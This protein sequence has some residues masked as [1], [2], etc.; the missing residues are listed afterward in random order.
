MSAKSPKHALL[1]YPGRRVRVF[2]GAAM[3]GAC[4]FCFLLLGCAMAAAAEER[5]A[6]EKD[7]GVS[8]VKVY[9]LSL[10]RDG[11]VDGISTGS[12]FVI[13]S[14]GYVVTNH[15]VVTG[16]STFFVLPDG[17]RTG[18]VDG[19]RDAN[20]I[21][22]WKSADVDL[23]LLRV[24]SEKLATL[25]LKPILLSAAPLSKGAAVKAIGFPGI[26]DS[27]G[28]T[29]TADEIA[30]STDT[31]G[32][33]G[34]LIDDGHMTRGGQSVH[35][36]QHDVNIKPGSSG[37]PLIDECGRVVGINTF[38]IQDLVRD[39][40]GNAIGTFS[41][42]INF[43][44]NVLELIKVLESKSIQF[45]SASEACISATTRLAHEV[46]RAE[47]TSRI[48]R[49]SIVAAG[50]GFVSMGL[51][52]YFVIIGPQVR[53]KA[54]APAESCPQ[55][56]SVRVAQPLATGYTRANSPRHGTPEHRHQPR[57]RGLILDGFGPSKE[58][59]RL[60]VD[61][62][63][64]GRNSVSLGREPGR[65]GLV[66]NDES[67]SRVH[68][69]LS[70]N[71]QHVMIRDNNSTNGTFVDGR[72]VSANESLVLRDGGEVKVGAVR[73]RVIAR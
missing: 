9:A 22:E 57:T 12:G 33:I 65:S 11:S 68:C 73:F 14:N 36:I 61:F 23:A 60:V 48:M 6:D 13:N 72:R 38:G 25:G 53:R 5:S 39:G 55:L 49:F 35:L 26:A 54:V 37:G 2:N 63:E 15:H 28:V 64:T 50:I 7:V 46:R 17:Q 18:I 16:G 29:Q 21:V 47:E 52:F 62:D 30:N 19:F 59:Y 71:G 8:I 24:K 4:A 51:M 41:S 45:A 44:S 43:A 31:S 58:R 3:L 66:V 27:A 34:R 56:P 69:E 1:V 20:A 70:S 42:G 10:S 32:S 40:A 67:V